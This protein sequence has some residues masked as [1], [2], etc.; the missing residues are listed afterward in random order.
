MSFYEAVE[1]TILFRGFQI[2]HTL[3]VPNANDELHHSG[4]NTCSSCHGVKECCD[5]PVRDKLILPGLGSDRVYVVDTGKDPKA[6]SVY[7]V[8]EPE[9]MH[10]FNCSTPHTTHCLPNGDIMISTMGDKDGN[11]KGDFVLIDGKTYRIKGTWTKGKTAKF[12]YDFWYQPYYDIMVSTEWGTPNVFKKGFKP[13][14]ALSEHYGRNL[15]FFSWSK[16]EL[17]ESFDLGEDGIAPLEVRFLHNPLE[18]QGFVGCAVNATVFRF[19]LEENGKIKVEKVIKIQPK[20]VSGWIDDHIQGN[21][22]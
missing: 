12:G 19:Y 6:P 1:K 21:D 5:V 18:K 22:Y 16:R 7:K 15:N 11:G 4:W 20:K 14:D 2:I 17:I 8:I 10:A 9:E 3:F 13:G